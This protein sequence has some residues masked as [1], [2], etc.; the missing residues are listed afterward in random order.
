MGKR[1]IHCPAVTPGNPTAVTRHRYVINGRLPS[2]T[3]H[4]RKKNE[5]KHYTIEK[6]FP[7]NWTDFDCFYFIWK[8][9]TPRYCPTATRKTLNRVSSCRRVEER[10]ET[11][12]K[13]TAT[14]G[15]L[16]FVRR[17]IR[18]RPKDK[19]KRDFCRFSLRQIKES[20][21][22]H[23]QNAVEYPISITTATGMSRVF[24]MAVGQYVINGRLPSTTL[25]FQDMSQ[26]KTLV[27]SV[28][29]CNHQ[30]AKLQA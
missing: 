12:I 2:T 21:L 20:P 17:G 3:L 30:F 4:F 13:S 7:N 22:L 11:D 29:F 5:K 24:L 6:E 25:H 28:N 16:S 19:S 14:F 1:S 9:M 15:K 26:N 27:K 23:P 18:F 8:L 10:R